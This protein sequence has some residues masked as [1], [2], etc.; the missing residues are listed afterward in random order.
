LCFQGERDR[1]GR[2]WDVFCE[3]SL[4]VSSVMLVERVD[5]DGND[6]VARLVQRSVALVGAE[7][8]KRTG[9]D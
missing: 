5:S 9:K 8:M 3:H 6:K 2:R 1:D 4:K 7:G